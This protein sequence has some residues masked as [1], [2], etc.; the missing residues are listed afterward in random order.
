MMVGMAKLSEL[1]A[2]GLGLTDQAAEVR[3]TKD[4]KITN[5]SGTRDPSHQ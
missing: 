3:G 5:H 4:S 2:V 1:L